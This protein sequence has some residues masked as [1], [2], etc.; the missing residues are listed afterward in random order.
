M[1]DLL[2]YPLFEDS[3]FDA[4]DRGRYGPVLEAGLAHNGLTIEDVLA[5]TQDF[6]LWAICR[7][8]IFRADLRG[9]FKKR[10][11]VN[12]LIPVSQ[13]TNAMA[14]PSGPHTEKI[15]IRGAGAE[16]LAEINFSAG[17]PDRTPESERAHCKH[18]METMRQA[19]SQIQ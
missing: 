16:K 9:V 6:G 1:N 7:Q 18:V 11:E 5:V 19:W 14:A 10:I 3:N 2:M 8:G 17:G 13:I 4:Y 15:V 12:D